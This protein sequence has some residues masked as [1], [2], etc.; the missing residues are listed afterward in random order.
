MSFLRPARRVLCDA[1]VLLFRVLT[2][3]LRIVFFLC[4]LVIPLPI[5]AFKRPTLIPDR[6]NLPAQVLKRE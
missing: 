2:Q 6:R 4:L 1:V 5:G 3:M